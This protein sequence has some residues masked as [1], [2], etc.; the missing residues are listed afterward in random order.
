MDETAPFEI[1][2][3]TP[4]DGPW[5]RFTNP[6]RVIAARDPG[7]VR[8]VLRQV[9]EEV[10]GGRYAAGFVSFEAA[11]AF[12][13][14]VRTL[15]SG[16]AVACFGI[17]EPDAV[18]R[19][20]RLPAA[21]ASTIGRWSA[22]IDRAA[23]L[24][25]IEAIKA[26]IEAGDTYQINFT[27]R[28]TAPF[29]GDPGAVMRHLFAAQA[30][31]WSARVDAGHH[32]ICSASPELFFS[33]EGERVLCR[34]MKGTWP[35]G[36]WAEQDE[37]R[38]DA[39]HLSAKNRA[40]NVMIV[41]MVRND[42]GRIARTGSIEVTSLFDVERYPLQW[43][44]TSTVTGTVE[45][46]GLEPLFGAMFPCGSITG[47]PKIRS[48]E[49]IQALESTPRG[50][51]TGAIGYAA[52]G[53]RAHFNVAIRTVVLDRRAGIAEF[54]VGSGV[55]W[56]SIARDEYDE[57]LL[58]AEML[59]GAGRRPDR[60]SASAKPSSGASY[61]LDDPPGFQLLETI[62]WTPQ[63]GFAL[64]DRHLRR[65]RASALCFG[66]ACSIDDVRARLDDAVG[67]LRGPARVRVLV[68]AD[69]G[70]VCEGVDLL[71][72][73]EPLSVALAVEPVDRRD[74]F[75]Y[76][77]T[78]RRAVYD[79]ARASRPDA[80][81]VILW[82]EDGEVTEGTEAN[83]VIMRDGVKVTPPVECGLLPG[84]MR[85]E[86]LERGELVE[87]RIPTA[88]LLRASEVWLVNSV[89]GSLRARVQSLRGRA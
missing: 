22:S 7:E 48:M 68:D 20:G 39:L 44:M 33:L 47:A 84:T 34:P 72:L 61:V 74:V 67:D 66:F 30:G 37:A 12:G 53:G 85:A 54:G 60:T 56:D 88:E 42:L 25:A 27:F 76:H 15:D 46:P 78:T 2:L 40:E 52:P 57:C 59:R 77:K 73:R 81:S 5:R 58:K 24:A 83:V 65:L 38:G 35:R 17:F 70:V 49:I 23:Y 50:I 63:T 43:Q 71:P 1:V 32:V 41:D 6:L 86:L 9:D 19:L 28:L 21:G 10:Q 13:L 4:W 8:A 29:T 55:V 45:R 3:R 69:G 31:S 11:A 62:L 75:L 14:P 64:L 87:R 18:E 79:R 36:Y 26:R 51:Y 82:N 80:D 16:L 89:R